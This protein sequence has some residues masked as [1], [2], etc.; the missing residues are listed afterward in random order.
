[1]DTKTKIVAVM[2]ASVAICMLIVAPLT[3]A[4]ESGVTLGDEETAA[5]IEECKPAGFGL[6]VKARFAVWFLRHAKAEEVSG[7]VVALTDKMLVLD[8]AEGQ[9]RVN[10]PSSWTVNGD[11]VSRE[12]LF[13]DGYIYEGETVTVKVLGAHAINSEGLEIS[14]FVGYELLTSSGLQATANLHIN[15]ED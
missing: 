9:V 11:V 13:T 8:T 15:I 5:Q 7:E 6:R 4:S 3:L 14:V 12:A 10:M 1:M 2:L